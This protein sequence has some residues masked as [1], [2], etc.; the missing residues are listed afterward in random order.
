MKLLPKSFFRQ[1][2]TSIA[3]GLLG[4][5]I[6]GGRMVGR[7]VETEAYLHDDPS[8]HS[9]RGKTLRNAPMFG[10][11]GQSYVYFT[12]GMYHCFNI[13]TG[14]K[15][16]GEAVLI[17]AVEPVSGIGIMKRNRGVGDVKNLCSG[18]AKFCIAFGLDKRHNEIDMMNERAKIKIMDSGKSE[19][20]DIVETERIGIRE[21]KVLP[22][23]FYI[24]GNEF[25]SKK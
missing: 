13:V 22:H 21:K 17:R 20:F 11:A 1:D 18:P 2:T 10:R 6:V 9:F 14:P 23:R 8:S 4:K 3:K 25:V 15:G 24:K 7:I 19:K 16:K 12:Y 5:Y